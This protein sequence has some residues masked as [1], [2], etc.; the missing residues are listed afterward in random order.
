[1]TTGPSRKAT[2]PVGTPFA[3]ETVAVNVTAAPGPAGLAEETS[4]VFV[5]VP[6]GARAMST[7]LDNPGIRLALITAPDVE[8]S[9]TWPLKPS[10][11]NRL[12]P[13]T[14]IS[15]GLVSPA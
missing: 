10:A 8:Y 1:M 4:V 2:V 6:A 3:P 13:E 5:A 7:G 14:S 9:P 12:V 15:D 11:T